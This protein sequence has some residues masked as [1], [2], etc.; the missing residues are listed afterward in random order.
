MG[1]GFDRPL[2]GSVQHRPD[3]QY[4]RRT[5]GFVQKQSV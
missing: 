5:R 4:L 3:L 1:R 2:P